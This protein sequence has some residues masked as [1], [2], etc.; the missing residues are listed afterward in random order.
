MSREQEH[1]R[2]IGNAI[3]VGVISELD[4]ANARVRVDAD[5]M[6]TDWLPFTARRAGPGV[7][8]WAAP[9]VGEQVVVV[10]PYGD[11]SQGVVLGSVYQDA[12][13]APA[14]AKTMTRT[15]FADGAF[16]QYDRAA[17]AHTVDVPAGGSITLHIGQTTLKLED[18]KATLT[19]P[20]LLVQSPKSTFTGAVTV[21]GLLT[22]Q[23]G[24]SGSGGSTTAAIQGNITVTG[25]N[26]TADGIGLKTHKHTG[27]QAGSGT[28]AGPTP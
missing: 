20:E 8:D 9:E 1:D 11:L 18:G 16:I 7:R 14:N 3:V 17:H 4:E 21:Q 28:S 2:Q 12:H 10:S 5:G 26:V 15:E 24:M 25:G 27:V 13:G 23:A 6:R 22:Y 19:T